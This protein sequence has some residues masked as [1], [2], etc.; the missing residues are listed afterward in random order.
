MLTIISESKLTRAALQLALL[1]SV[2]TVHEYS[3]YKPFQTSWRGRGTKIPR[4]SKEGSSHANS[5]LDSVT[6]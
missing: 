2:R 4:P 3:N 6:D 5:M 1:S